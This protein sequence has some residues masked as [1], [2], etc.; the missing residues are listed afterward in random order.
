MS[1][2]RANPAPLSAAVKIIAFLVLA[3]VAAL[4]FVYPQQLREYRLYFTE[5]RP[6][7]VLSYETMSQDW[8]EE[9][10]KAQMQ[11]IT[12]RCYDNRPGEYLDQR[13]CFAD[14]SSHN[15][16]PAMS[17]AFYFAAGK[18][19][20]MTVQVPW[21]K[22]RALARSMLAAY[23]E[24]TGA[25]AVPVAGVRLVGWQLR[26]GNAI[27]MNR[28]QPLNPLTWSMV[29]WSSARSCEPRGCFLAQSQ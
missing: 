6:T 18:L 13:S 24:L 29:M 20:H 27:F 21:W 15:G 22:H 10:V 12:L 1:N 2:V 8:S 3:A 11:G 26:S 23:G 14:V 7:T 16:I 9:E 17:L 5:S 25:Q 4:F 19:N 28:D